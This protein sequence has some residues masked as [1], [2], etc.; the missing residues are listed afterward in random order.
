[1]VGS[2]LAITAAGF[3][4]ISPIEAQLPDSSASRQARSHRDE[5]LNRVLSD[6]SDPLALLRA[7]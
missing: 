2:W 3:A 6:I 5:L 1:M 4:P 7:L